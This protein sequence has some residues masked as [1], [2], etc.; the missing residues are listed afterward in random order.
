TRTSSSLFASNV[1]VDS[2][3]IYYIHHLA[4]R[5]TFNLRA[6]YEHYESVNNNTQFFPAAYV[7]DSFNPV[8]GPEYV[9]LA[10][11]LTTSGSGINKTGQCR[12]SQR[13][14]LRSDLWSG[15]A[16]IDWQLFKRLST[17]VVFRYQDRNGDELLFG[18]NYDK[19]NAGIG[20]RYD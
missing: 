18:Q 9:C 5:V 8:T 14:A 4:P 3:A 16:R 20:F 10:G 17:F 13:S 15:V 2:Y 11:S 19:L 7:F 6:S 12:I 1:N